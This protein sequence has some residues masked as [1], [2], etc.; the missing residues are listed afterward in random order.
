M[1]SASTNISAIRG[2]SEARRS[3]RRICSHQRTAAQMRQFLATGRHALQF[4]PSHSRFAAARFRVDAGSLF[5]KVA[6]VPFS[7]GADVYEGAPTP[8]T[9]YVS[10]ASNRKLRLASALFLVVFSISQETWIYL[11][12]WRSLAYLGNSPR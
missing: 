2:A 8:I 1:V 6:A 3:R 11:V 12:A 10:I 4:I 7:V 5:F 9:A